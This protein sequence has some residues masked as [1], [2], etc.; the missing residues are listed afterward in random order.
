[1]RASSVQDQGVA[2]SAR[3]APLGRAEVCARGLFRVSATLPVSPERLTLRHQVMSVI[4]DSVHGAVDGERREDYD[5]LRLLLSDVRVVGK[6]LN[7]AR[8]HSVAR[9]FGVSREDSVLVTVVALGALAAAGQ[10]KAAKLLQ[11]PPLPELGNVLLGG[12]GVGGLVQSVAGDVSQEIPGFGALVVLAVIATSMRPVARRSWHEART[13]THAARMGF[14][15][16]YGHMF[17]PHRRVR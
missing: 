4:A 15:H 3:A 13:A 10:R 6:L 11:G 16:R 14:D 5:G 2:V 8:Y 1:M 7:E 9:L 12:T 17:R